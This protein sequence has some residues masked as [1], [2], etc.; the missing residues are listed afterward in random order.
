MRSCVG[1][2]DGMKKWTDK[3]YQLLIRINPNSSISAINILSNEFVYTI[4]NVFSSLLGLAI[5]IPVL[6]IQI[7]K[8]ILSVCLIFLLAVLAKKVVVWPLYF[9]PISLILP[10]PRSNPVQ[11]YTNPELIEFKSIPTIWVRK[12]SKLF[13]F[14]ISLSNIKPHLENVHEMT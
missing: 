14:Q 7:P 11:V 13:Q 1:L 6:K 12:A 2:V 9:L 5:F 3:T 10:L 8:L 4:F